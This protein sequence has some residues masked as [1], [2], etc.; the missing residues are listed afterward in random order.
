M[1][2]RPMSLM[3]L[4]GACVW[5]ALC[6]AAVPDPLPDWRDGA[7]KQRLVQF[8]TATSRP[9]DARFVPA[10]ARVAVFDNDGTLWSE[11]PMYV[12][13]AFALDR[14]KALAPQ[15]PE[16]KSQEPFS[17]VLAG[18][19]KGAVAGG[20]KAAVELLMAT[21]AG[22]TSEEFADTVRQWLATARN[23]LTGRLYT[24]MTY[25]PMVELLHYVRAHGYKTY[26]VSGGGVEFMRVFAQEA[27]GVRPEQ[28]IGS[29]IVSS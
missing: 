17:S 10:E 12:Q 18:D 16:W 26:I 11:Q 3:P 29:R 20:D 7:A 27:Y 13:L 25:Q 15:H 28:V 4:L 9:G 24:Q 23:P 8:V 19:L 2:L 14:I 5:V 21:H 22:M 1:N 6:Q